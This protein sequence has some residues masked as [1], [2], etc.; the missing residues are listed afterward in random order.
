WCQPQTIG[1]HPGCQRTARRSPAPIP[2]GGPPMTGRSLAGL[3]LALALVAPLRA[4]DP[5]LPD[6]AAFDKSVVDALRDIHNKG[7]DL[8]NTSK[9]YA[10]AYRL[11][12]GSLA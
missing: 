6:V 8:F 11:Y 7:A 5:K 1:L 4:D 2:L 9:D 10:G 3:F 12:Q